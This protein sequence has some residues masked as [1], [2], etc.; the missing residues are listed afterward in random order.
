MT[1]I[2]KLKLYELFVSIPGVE[3]KKEISMYVYLLTAR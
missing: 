2:P 1:K 3:V